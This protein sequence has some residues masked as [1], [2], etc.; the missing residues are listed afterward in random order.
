MLS[1]LTSGTIL[2]AEPFMIDE[3]FKRS[4]VLLVDHGDDGSVGFIL[5]RKTDVVIDQLVDDFPA[6]DA[7]VYFGGPVGTD[8]VHY[9]HRKGDLLPGSDEVAKGVFWGGDY[10]QLKTMIDTKVID[11]RDIRFFVGYSGWSNRQLSQEID[12]G[13]W[14]IADADAN[15][16]FNSQSETLWSKVMKHKGRNFEVIGDIDDGP[17]YN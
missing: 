12:G 14:V 8:T 6:C 15:Y 7:P 4:A 16:V 11:Q 3:N 5:N 9:L 1:M 10:A 17:R 13:S 2:L